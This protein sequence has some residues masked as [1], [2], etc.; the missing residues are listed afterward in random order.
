MSHWSNCFGIQCVMSFSH[1]F[2]P[3]GANQV[4][5]N[6]I[7]SIPYEF[8][9][10]RGA[11]PRLAAAPPRWPPAAERVAPGQLSA[12]GPPAAAAVPRDH[13]VARPTGARLHRLEMDVCW[14]IY[15]YI[16]IYVY[17][18]MYIYIYACIYIYMYVYMYINTVG[19]V[20]SVKISFFLALQSV[21]GEPPQ[22]VGSIMFYPHPFVYPNRSYPSSH[23]IKLVKA[24]NIRS[25]F[26]EDA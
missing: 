10:I 1:L 7:D 17:I 22:R 4:S 21:L 6:P 23:R 20:K 14:D 18:Y 15:I 8:P 9:K 13:R 26:F 5:Q 11:P 3:T 25:V 16:Y 19:Q 2:Q 24:N 12:S